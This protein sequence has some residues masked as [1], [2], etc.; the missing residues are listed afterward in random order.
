MENLERTKL[1]W[2]EEQEIYHK[3]YDA[4]FSADCPV[5]ITGTSVFGDFSALNKSFSSRLPDILM[6]G[7]KNLS[8][9]MLNEINQIQNRFTSLGLIILTASVKYEDLSGVHTDLSNNRNPF[10]LF[11]KKSL[12]R[13]EQY[14]SVISLVKMG[15]VVIDPSLTNVISTQKEKADLAG[16]LTSREM[17]ILN[18]IAKGLTNVAISGVLCIDI[19]TVRHHINPILCI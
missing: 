5:E 8:Q 14:F 17:E 10:A 13:S 15:Q 19:K 9:P 4:I 7:C 12:T 18:L 2:A 3:L 6:I 1:Y 11:L 16:G